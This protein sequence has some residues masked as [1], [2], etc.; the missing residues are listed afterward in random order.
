[1]TDATA[2]REPRT[3]IFINRNYGLLWFGQAISL[4]GDEVFDLTLILWI[5]TIIALGPDGKP[6]S[7]APFAVALLPVCVLVPS[8]IVGPIAG[9]FV[10]R[11]NKRGL[12]LRM[13][14]LRAFLVATLLFISGLVPL[15]FELTPLIKLVTIYIVVLLA[16]I[17]S[18]FFNPARLALIGDVVVPEYRGQ[19]SGLAQFSMALAMII[20]P[21]L[22]SPLLFAFGVRWAL[23]INAL[24]FVLSFLCITL[25]R[26]PQAASSVAPGEKPSFGKEFRAGLRITFTNRVIR[27]VTIAGI[28]ASFG[29]GAFN[30]LSVFF[31]TQNL[32]T[33][34]SYVGFVAAAFGI[35]AI[36]GAILLSIFARPIGITRLFTGSFLF[37][38][39]IFLLFTRQTSF[40]LAI[41]LVVLFGVGQSALN[42]AIGPMILNAAPREMIGRVVSILNP[43]IQ[44][45]S[46]ISIV[47]AGSLAS[48]VLANFHAQALGMHFGTFDTIF[49]VS[50][51]LLILGGIYAIVMLRGTHADA[52]PPTPVPVPQPALEG[53]SA[54]G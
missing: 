17:C 45:S 6:Q 30:G 5:S 1:M 49:S 16:T 51:L 32:H 35:G 11:W 38:G 41:F 25:V 53:E 7:W 2:P 8:F 3:G 33:S 19:A 15:P 28:I 22:A 47:I 13:D 46:L 40:A 4:I 9:V 12:M 14:L 54:H 23:L 20:G 37:V 31:V 48:S 29:T 36:I 42:S 27:T 10:D 43:A 24:S 44:F 52:P 21:P 50:A 26:A 34:A 18:Q 39:I